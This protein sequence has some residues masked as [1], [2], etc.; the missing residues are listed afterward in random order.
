MKPVVSSVLNT[1]HMMHFALAISCGAN[2]GF[3]AA[4][5]DAVAGSDHNDI[6]PLMNIETLALCVGNIYEGYH[7]NDDDLIKGIDDI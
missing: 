2:E 1:V 5:Y 7:E 6:C 4:A 3:V